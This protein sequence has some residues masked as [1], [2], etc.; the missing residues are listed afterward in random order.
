MKLVKPTF[1]I[2]EQEFPHQK[3]D[4][5]SHEHQRALEDAMYRHIEL[6]G[7]T[8]YKSQDKIIEGSA[9]PFVNRMIASKHYAMLEHGTVY[10]YSNRD[11]SAWSHLIE[12]YSNNKYSIVKG[13]LADYD[14]CV[15]T[16]LRV[17]AENDWFDDLKYLC[18]PTEFHAKRYT[19]KFQTNIQ[20]YKEYTRHRVMSW[21]IES[22]RYCN[23]LKKKFGGCVTFITPVWL[24]KSKWYQKLAFKTSLWVAEKMYLFL[25]KTGWKPQEA[26][27]ILPQATKAEVVMTGF[28]EDFKHFFDLRAL[29]TTG[30]PHPQAKELAEPLMQEFIKREYIKM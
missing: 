3:M 8:C 11:F 17:L 6:C 12:R 4:M 13:G 1:E 29:G 25:I 16:N 9:K 28:V 5:D 10:L 15:T 22:T 7:R 24:N 23:Y 2:I 20:V 26:A 21:A 14:C 30:A 27:N 18:E 19:V